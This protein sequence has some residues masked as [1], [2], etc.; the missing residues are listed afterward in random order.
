MKQRVNWRQ[1]FAE[2]GLLLVGALLALSADALWSD[3]QDRR[4]EAE[5][6]ESIRSDLEENAVALDFTESFY[7]EVL[8]ADSTVLAYAR[9]SSDLSQDSI[10][11][12]TMRAFMMWPFRPSLGTYQ[13]MVASGSLRLIQDPEIR[14]EL[15]SFVEEVE[16]LQSTINVLFE[17]WNTLEEPFIIAEL[18]VTAIYDGYPRSVALDQL[19]RLGSLSLAGDAGRVETV[20]RSQEL[21]NHIAM[22]MVLVYDVLI[23]IGWLRDELVGLQDLLAGGRQP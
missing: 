15:V 2:V 18:P 17:R 9:G 11:R 3:R 10:R 8:V 23:S 19:E 13:D 6:L 21:A 12:T 5:Y 20:P 22:R 7:R 1:V 16:V 14:M 4:A